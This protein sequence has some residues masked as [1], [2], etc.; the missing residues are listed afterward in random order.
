M[1]PARPA[2]SITAHERPEVLLDQLGN[3]ARFVRDPLVVVHLN[4]DFAASCPP[5]L[6][7][8]LRRQAHLRIN[9]QHLPTRWAHMFHAHLSNFRF[10]RDSGEA[11]THF[12][13]T[14][15]ADLFFR[16][17]IEA[18]IAPFDAG[19]ND[20]ASFTLDDEPTY[21]E[22][23]RRL[24]QDGVAQR[25][26]RGIG[27]TDVIKDAHEG[28]FYRREVLEPMVAQLD[29][30][31]TDWE[32]DDRYPKEEFFLRNLLRPM[33]ARIGP[34][35]AHVLEWGSTA[36]LDRAVVAA[37]L[38]ETGLA[39]LVPGGRLARWA[40]SVEPPPAE[41][42]DGVFALSRI[43][44]RPDHPLR[45]LLTAPGWPQ[46]QDAA[47]AVARAFRPHQLLPLERAGR[48]ALGA[49][50]PSRASPALLKGLDELPAITLLD[51][52]L[53]MAMPPLTMAIEAC[54]DRFVAPQAVAAPG[55]H[56]QACAAMLE[57][58]SQLI[59]LPAKDGVECAVHGQ[60]AGPDGMVFLFWDAPPMELER[61]WLGLL[62][63]AIRPET[64]AVMRQCSLWLEVHAGD[65]S[66]GRFYAPSP[67]V[68]EQGGQASLIFDLRDAMAA[69]RRLD[70][71]EG[72]R[73]LAY[74][75]LPVPM[76]PQRIRTLR[77]LAC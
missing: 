15:S 45:E 71:P 50:A 31:I 55:R 13:L 44:R 8:L 37:V 41:R 17:G 68:V 73:V 23:V 36:D 76:P 42:M 43:P 9:P 61:D 51:G 49:E 28:S 66:L 34:R 38:R 25:L 6:L 48:T 12:V 3:I 24:R 46:A 10:L 59:M 4:R 1:H 20:P 47:R 64:A 58:P 14:S 65:G 21:D 72:Y 16:E 63:C 7:A 32:Y 54:P 11:F 67:L 62:S 40:E 69:I 56:F 39:G 19:V 35:I 2:F 18:A 30:V 60:P 77:L 52:K 53:G 74:L 75:R 70:R 57:T 5:A 27:L 26:F 29:A 22:W 33:Q